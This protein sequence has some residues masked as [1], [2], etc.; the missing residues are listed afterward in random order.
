MLHVVIYACDS[1]TQE[2]EAHE[3][4]LQ[5]QP[6]LHNT[7]QSTQKTCTAKISDLCVPLISCL[8]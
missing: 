1:S 7:F 4:K 5:G 8:Y 6:G 2:V 3:L